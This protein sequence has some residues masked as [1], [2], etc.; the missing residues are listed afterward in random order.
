MQVFNSIMAMRVTEHD[1]WA[2][3][4]HGQ[5]YSNLQSAVSLCTNDTYY[6]NGESGLVRPSPVRPHVLQQL[7]ALALVR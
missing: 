2:T 7:V 1:V 3:M 6:D 4:F 5:C